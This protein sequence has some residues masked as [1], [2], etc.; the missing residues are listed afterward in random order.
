MLF[1]G[2]YLATV[3]RLR[4][5]LRLDPH[6]TDKRLALGQAL[7][8]LGEVDEALDE[9]R[10]VLEERPDSISTRLH[11]ATALMAKRRWKEAKKELAEIIAMDDTVVAAHHNLAAVLYSLGD[12]R[13]AIESYRT[14]LTLAPESIETHYHLGLVLRLAGRKKD[15]V[16]EFQAAAEAGHPKAQY[17]LG[18]AYSTGAGVDRDLPMA[19][20]WWMAASEHGVPEARDALSRLRKTALKSNPAKSPN[21]TF[22]AFE[23]YRN[24]LWFG[25]PELTPN[26]TDET[27]GIALLQAFRVD[28]AVPTLIREAMALDELSERYLAALY[29]QGLPTYLEP[30]DPRILRYFELAAGDGAPQARLSLARIHALGLG[31]PEDRGKALDILKGLPKA[32]AEQFLKDLAANPAGTPPHTVPETEGATATAPQP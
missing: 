8:G 10:L 16:P 24:D 20:R 18:A 17:F 1:D 13:G 14:A 27:V 15:A 22:K 6:A 32:Y 28:E 26:G 5:E 12:V 21:K 25:F 29:E 11:I 7:F 9:Y 23:A 19:I 31:V 4:R 2:D 30:H 3:D